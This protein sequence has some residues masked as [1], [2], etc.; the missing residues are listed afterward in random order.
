METI[1][2]FAGAHP[3]LT[4]T[5]LIMTAVT[6]AN[7]LRLRAVGSSELAP[8]QAV[9]RIN[10]GAKVIDVRSHERFRAGH[11]VSAVNIAADDI[12]TKAD[13]KLAAFRDKPLLVYDDTGFGAAKVARQ[14]RSLNFADVASLKGG[15][16]AWA[17]D[18]LPLESS[19]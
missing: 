13:K 3:L 9:L 16:T 8:Q 1:L 6:L 7:E 5:A 12:A 15:I 10:S 17:A 4:V 11:I 2:Q 14:L 19:K 18:K